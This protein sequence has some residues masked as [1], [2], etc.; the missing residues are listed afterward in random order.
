MAIEVIEIQD[1]PNDL[2][3]SEVWTVLGSGDRVV[4][5]LAKDVAR[6]TELS[7]TLCSPRGLYTKLEVDQVGPKGVSFVDG[8]YL[9]GKFLAHCFEGAREAIYAVVTVGP[10]LE[11]SEAELFAEGSSVEAIVLDAVGSASIMNAFSHISNLIYDDVTDRG[12]QTGMCLQPG[13]SY[14]DVTGQREIFQ[15]LP[16]ERI[17]VQLLESCFMLPQKSQSGIIPLGPE[18][19]VHSDPDKSYCRYCQA[20]RCPMRMEPAI[21]VSL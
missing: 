11:K 3:E 9:D 17:G 4:P 19:K 15:V 10:E 5:G 12:W 21:E 14:W 18:L 1:V 8:P 2:K 16:A 20:T 7:K 6:G 13:Q